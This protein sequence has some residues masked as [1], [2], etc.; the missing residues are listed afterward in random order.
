MGLFDFVG[1][2]LGLSPPSAGEAMSKEDLLWLMEKGI[3]ANQIDQQGIFT[4]S[5][6]TGGEGTGQPRTQTTTVNPGLE[7]GIARMMEQVGAE[8]QAY[9]NP[10]EDLLGSML[11]E[12]HASRGMGAPQMPQNADFSFSPAYPPQMGPQRPA[13]APPAPNAPPANPWA[14][15]RQGNPIGGP[16]PNVS[17]I[18]P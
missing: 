8:P 6:Y 10:F 16:P 13:Q 9:K 15:P 7:A 5:R 2:L 12:R 14:P 11:A 3:L 1:D 4:G 17:W 18:N